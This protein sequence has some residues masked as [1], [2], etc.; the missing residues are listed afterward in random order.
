MMTSLDVICGLAL[1]QSKILVTLVTRSRCIK[2]DRFDTIVHIGLI[3]VVTVDVCQRFK[4]QF[5]VSGL[6]FLWLI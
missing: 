3:T 4:N 6:S 5:S 1:T 2:R